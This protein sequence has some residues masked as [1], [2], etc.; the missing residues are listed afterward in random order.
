M[1][2]G[3]TSSGLVA[4]GKTSGPT[5]V[6]SSEG[7]NGTS[8]FSQPSGA[9]ARAYLAGCGTAAS[10]LGFG[11]WNQ[12]PGAQTEEFTGGTTGANIADFTTS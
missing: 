10:A 4:F 8:W 5:A 9:N 11:S 6:S 2:A 1:G 12:T 7:W 3:T